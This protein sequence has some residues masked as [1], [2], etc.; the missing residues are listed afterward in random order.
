MKCSVIAEKTETIEMTLCEKSYH[1][2][3]LTMCRMCR[4]LDMNYLISH[5]S[6]R[7]YDY[8]FYFFNEETVAQRSRV[9]CLEHTAS[10]W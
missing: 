4:P 10:R 5:I 3:V 7:R 1:H 9:A 2:W 8:Y 6:P